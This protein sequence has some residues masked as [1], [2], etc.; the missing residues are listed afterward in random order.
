[1]PKFK[2]FVCLMLWALIITAC[3]TP[4]TTSMPSQLETPAV[5]PVESTA[6][7]S[8]EAPTQIPDTSS[9]SAIDAP[10]IEAPS[11]VELDM[12]N[13]MDGWAVT[14]TQIVRTN[15]GVVTWYDV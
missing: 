5:Q 10:L 4:A 2:F 11:L 8:A 3:S 12:L 7:Q 9:Q 13:E 6:T 1:M 14:E 15:D